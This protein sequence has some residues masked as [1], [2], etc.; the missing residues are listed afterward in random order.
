MQKE[1]EKMILEYIPA[2]RLRAHEDNREDDHGEEFDELIASIREHGIVQPLN[3]RRTNC[4]D[5]EI[6]GGHRRWRAALKI[7]LDFVPCN[8]R[9]C[10]EE[11]ALEILL[12]ENFIRHNLNMVEE[13]EAVDIAM[14]KMG[15]DI[16]QIT[17]RF[18]R[19]E[20][21]VQMSMRLL[22][23]S[24]EGRK[25]VA[26]GEVRK[27]TVMASLALDDQEDRDM[28]VQLCFW[29][30]GQSVPLSPYQARQVIAAEIVAPRAAEKAW[31]ANCE[32]MRKKLAKDYKD[33]ELV[34]QVLDYAAAKK[35]WEDFSLA[36]VPVAELVP[37]EM[38]LDP[39]VLLTWGAIG[40][41]HGA[42]AYW[43]PAC[44]WME[45][46]L[47]VDKNL[48]LVA[49]KT[50]SEQGR[51]CLLSFAR[52][53][54]VPQKTKDDDFPEDDAPE[55]PPDERHVRN[56]AGSAILIEVE[57]LER[58]EEYVE[59]LEK[60]AMEVTGEAWGEWPMWMARL[61]RSEKSA[62]IAREVLAWVRRGC[63]NL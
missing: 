37:L 63:V 45:E 53:P 46:G 2:K 27:E 35:M 47:Y 6:L 28:A 61:V 12:V 31:N 59:A 25:L 8:V 18:S 39:Q 5:Y 4:G 16:P 7:G 56:T 38:L 29:P 33:S 54:Q 41:A 43:L 19:S 55:P 24:A 51:T 32:K 52:Q 58:V 49:E 3:V 17:K 13:A 23:I 10:T 22:D 15:W 60:G 42:P 26:S 11:E 20:A 57:R 44:E 36:F 48:L 62:L 34:P 14:R 9:E 40:A 21:W 50:A 30:A 1:D